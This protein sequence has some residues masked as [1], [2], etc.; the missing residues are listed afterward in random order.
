MRLLLVEDDSELAAGIAGDFRREGY[1]VDCTGDGIEAEYLGREDIYDAVILD[2]GLPGKPG[3]EVLRSWRTGGLTVPVLV[4]TARDAWSER[5][6]GLKAGADDY[7][8][9][10]FHAEELSAR[11]Q[12]LLRRSTGRADAQLAAGGLLLDEERQTGQLA[13]GVETQLTG[14]EFRLLRYFMTHADR[15]L[16]KSRLTDHIY[17]EDRGRDS[18]VLE[19]YVRR[20]RDKIGRDSIETR[21]GQ[22][23]LFRSRR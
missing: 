17:E 5:V 13:D 9:K 2:L 23:Y 8:G 10:P 12:A 14:I 7:L 16:S 3:L 22:G 21:R 18:N 15:V 11:V 4:L 1:A 20:L 19:V 6:A